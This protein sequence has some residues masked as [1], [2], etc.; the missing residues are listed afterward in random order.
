MRQDNNAQKD[1]VLSS[2]E[3]Y[4]ELNRHTSPPP[5]YDI[6]SSYHNSEI[7][8]TEDQTSEVSIGSQNMFFTNRSFF[9]SP[10]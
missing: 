5:L 2:F 7:S 9:K 6:I 4:T 10:F 3:G 1:F 8:K